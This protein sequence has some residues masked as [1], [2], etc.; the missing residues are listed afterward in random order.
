VWLQDGGDGLRVANTLGTGS[1]KGRLV[2]SLLVGAP[3]LGKNDER[4]LAFEVGKRLAYLRPE[5]FATLALGSLAKLESAFTAAISASGAKLFAHDGKPYEATTDDARKLASTIRTQVPGAM[6]E[7]VGDLGSKLSGRVGNGL[8]TS[9]RSATDHTANR[10]GFILA[11]DLEIAAKMIATENAAMSTL[12][13]KDRLRELL[14]FSVSEGYFQVRRH[15]G[16][17][18]RD[19]ASA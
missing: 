11:N 6:L 7:Q 13:V 14:A 5:R 3:Q 1:E 10:V 9:W 15:L 12:P 17:H 16:L 4:E 8:I 2:P 19:E 18:V